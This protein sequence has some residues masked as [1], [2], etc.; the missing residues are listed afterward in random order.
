M[1]GGFAIAPASPDS[2]STN[3]FSTVF[4]LYV[5]LAAVETAAPSLRYAKY[6]V[7]LVVIALV[8]VSPPP[9]HDRSFF[10]RHL[11]TL[12]VATVVASYLSL[13]SGLYWGTLTSRFWSEVVF[14][15]SPLFVASRAFPYVDRTRVNSY[16]VHA[17]WILAAGYLIERGRAIVQTFS[18]SSGLLG[19]M[20]T[21]SVGSESNLS[22][23]FGLLSLFFVFTRRR[24]LALAAFIL[25]VVSFKRIAILSVVVCALVYWISRRL[26]ESKRMRAA[27]PLLMVCANAGAFAVLYLLSNGSFDDFI[28]EATGVPTN[29]VT[30]G[31]SHLYEVLFYNIQFHTFG[32]GLGRITSLLTTEAIGSMNAHS[33][34]IKYTL[35]VGPVLSSVWIYLLYRGGS[36]NKA[37]FALCVFINLQFVTDNVSVYVPVM[38]LFYALHGFLMIG[39]E[40]E[41]GLTTVAKN[42]FTR[43]SADH[44]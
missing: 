30:M 35:E 24:G 12:L 11:T 31:R 20:L 43:R 33:D 26:G 19:Q 41:P 21:S 6:S 32:E 28:T 1:S 14:V 4:F 27:L 42:T 29:W 3:V 8:A 36:S 37:T 16:A 34:V 17:F 39:V 7:P 40:H 2:R 25:T 5:V 23:S 10:S 13:L 22:F 44:A 15:L 18:H 38:F 9:R